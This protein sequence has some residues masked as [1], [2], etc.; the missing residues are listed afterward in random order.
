MKWEYEA[1][2]VAEYV[3]SMGLGDW[4]HLS[5]RLNKMGEMGWELVSVSNGIAYFKRCKQTEPSNIIYNIAGETAIGQTD[6]PGGVSGR[7]IPDHL[8]DQAIGQ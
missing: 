5:H 3:P 8:K 7:P 4:Q 6:Y 1:V 2:G